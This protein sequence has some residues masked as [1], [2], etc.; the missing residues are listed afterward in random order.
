[1]IERVLRVLCHFCT[2]LPDNAV[3]NCTQTCI[4]WHNTLQRDEF[5]PWVAR[6]LC[7]RTPQTT[8]P[9]LATMR[10]HQ[11]NHPETHQPVLLSHL[12]RSEM[13]EPPEPVATNDE[14]T[15]EARNFAQAFMHQGELH[16]VGGGRHDY[17]FN[18]G[19]H[20]TTSERQWVRERKSF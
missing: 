7:V 16:V 4:S 17:A 3:V 12:L 9:R 20:S 2:K 19:L 18:P 6:L 11:P 15:I 1:M 5:K 8:Q 13:G 10:L 14:G